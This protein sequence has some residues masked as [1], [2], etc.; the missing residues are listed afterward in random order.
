MNHKIEQLYNQFKKIKKLEYL[1]STNQ[2]F[3]SVNSTFNYYLKKANLE[4]TNNLTIKVKRSYSKALVTLFNLTPTGPTK[5]E[6]ARL[7][8]LYGTKNILYPNQQKLKL[9]VTASK[10]TISNSNY[11]FLLK[12]DYQEK[13]L[14]LNIYNKRKELID[15][16]TYWSFDKLEKRLLQK[17]QFLVLVK[18]WPNKVGEHEYFKYYKMTVYK[19]KSFS[20]FLS[21]LESGKI[22][23]LLRITGT[24]NLSKTS[25]TSRNL[26]FCISEEDLTYL[27]NKLEL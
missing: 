24:T 4:I 7:S 2:G 20:N 8:S 5:K 15:K 1:K 19:L 12:V 11:Y 9:I 13:K 14:Y 21:S 27:F 3:T 23:L 26:N 17:L 10:K 25:L 16:T 6:I 18:A 22:K